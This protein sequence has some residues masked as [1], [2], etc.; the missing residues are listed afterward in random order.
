[1]SVIQVAFDIPPAIQKGIDEG[2]LIRFGGVVRDTAGH[3]V[4]H[5]DEVTISKPESGVN[6][7]I[8]FAKKIKTF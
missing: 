4:K 6:K 3:V 2:T 8:E 1:M 5:L 7:I